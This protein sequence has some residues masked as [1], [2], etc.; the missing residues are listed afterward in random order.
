MICNVQM[1][2][3]QMIFYVQMLIL[4]MMAVHKIFGKLYLL[5]MLQMMVKLMISY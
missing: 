5:K 2:D 3:I 4:L 1:I